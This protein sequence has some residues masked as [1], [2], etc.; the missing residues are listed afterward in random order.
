MDENVKRN[1]FYS[2]ECAVVTFDY[3][4]ALGGG[5]L[6]Q[7]VE[8]NLLVRSESLHSCSSTRENPTNVL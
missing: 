1:L 6:A 8:N 3:G 7:Y 5:S 2:E 4:L